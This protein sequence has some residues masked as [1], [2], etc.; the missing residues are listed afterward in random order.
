M[1]PIK[2]MNRHKTFL[3]EKCLNVTSILVTWIRGVGTY[4][5]ITNNS[6]RYHIHA[7]N[8]LMHHGDCSK[9]ES[10]PDEY[11]FPRECHIA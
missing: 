3:Q 4:A 6:S 5:D 10:W 8:Y 9:G 11:G 1:I 2:T 7:G